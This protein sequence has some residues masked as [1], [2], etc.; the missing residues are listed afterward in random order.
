[1]VCTAVFLTV[2]NDGLALFRLPDGNTSLMD[3]A[4]SHA[5]AQEIERVK[6]GF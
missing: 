1:M 2:P 6:D 4:S 3:V 5:S